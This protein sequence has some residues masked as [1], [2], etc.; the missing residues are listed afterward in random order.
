MIEKIALIADSAC[1]LPQ[2]LVKE[3]GIK[4]LPLKVIY[5]YGQFSDRIDIDPVDV[6]K[7]MPEEIPTT[8]MPNLQEIKAMFE[9]ARQ[10]G[11]TH[12]LALALSSGLSGTYQA[13][14]LAAKDFDDVVIKV[15]D[16]K[17]LS[18][19]TGWMVLD[20]ARNIL[21]GLSYNKVLEKLTNLQPKVRAYYVIETLD[22]LRKGGRIGH[23]AGMLGEML[24][25]KP[26]IGVNAEGVYY[27]HAKV[28]GRS[29]S[30]EKL[31]DIVVQSVGD[32]PFNL[33]VMHGGA[34]ETGEKLMATLTSRLPN[35][36]ELIFSDISPALGVHTGP[37]LLAVCF[38][39]V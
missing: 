29:K 12:L 5:P 37:G 2:K 35:V 22:Y 15:F 23:V 31:I 21:S 10:E 3:Y 19:A 18:M 14:K 26:I 6:Y 17:T 24:N 13:M 25:L 7:R 16:T 4:I 38:Y 20:T 32:R 9:S 8:S 11:F 34:Q 1:D 33:A 36:R 28:R 30:I 27:T 39:E